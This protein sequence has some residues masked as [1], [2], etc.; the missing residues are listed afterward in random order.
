MPPQVEP[1]VCTIAQAMAA[2]MVIAIQMVMFLSEQA[3]ENEVKMIS[4]LASYGLEV[5]QDCAKENRVS[6]GKLNH[7]P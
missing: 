1:L 3:T 2:G 7:I 5:A 4:D 6:L